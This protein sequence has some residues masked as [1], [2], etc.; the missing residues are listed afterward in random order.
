MFVYAATYQGAGEDGRLTGEPVHPGSLETPNPAAIPSWAGQPSSSAWKPAVCRG[1]LGLP[2]CS[3]TLASGRQAG[4]KLH[5]GTATAEA[6]YWHLQKC[7]HPGPEL[8]TPIGVKTHICFRCA[9]EQ[10]HLEIFQLSF[11]V[12][13]SCEWQRWRNSGTYWASGFLLHVLSALFSH[14]VVCKPFCKNI[15]IK[16]IH[17]PRSYFSPRSARRPPISHFH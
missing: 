5:W 15:K 1:A 12:Q 4:A 2:W 9:A 16:K 3:P 14:R 8:A 10:C 7:F 11:T 13:T 6:G 17:F